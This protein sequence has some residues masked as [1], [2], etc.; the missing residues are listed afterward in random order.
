MDAVQILDRYRTSLASDREGLL[1]LARLLRLGSLTEQELVRHTRIPHH[2]L[3]LK[4][5][6]LFRAQLACMVAGGRWTTTD[7]AEETLSRL[8][9]ASVVAR[10]VLVDQELSEID[11]SFLEACLEARSH[12]DGRWPRYQ[13]T[14]LRSLEALREKRLQGKWSPEKDRGEMS[15]SIVVGLDSDVQQLGG[16]QYCGS[17]LDWHRERESDLWA[18][19]GTAWFKNKEGL[20]NKCLIAAERALKSNSIMSVDWTKGEETW[21]VDKEAAV[22][23]FIRLVGT[24][25]SRVLD[26][27]IAASFRAN[28]RLAF[29]AWPALERKLPDLEDSLYEILAQLGKVDEEARA[30][31]GRRWV[32]SRLSELLSAEESSAAGIGRLADGEVQADL[33]SVLGPVRGEWLERLLVRIKS[34]I[35]EG[36]YDHVSISQR[37]TLGR[38]LLEASRAIEDRTSLGSD[39]EAS[40]NGGEP[41]PAVGRRKRRR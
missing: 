4:M 28:H 8:G 35:D 17:I 9:I 19:Y 36:H 7:L 26:P 1:I 37:T 30:A 25:V 23:T 18:R 20:D 32:E 40:P 16:P 14:L 41:T 34:Q 21:P 33:Q 31:T 27:G 10:S 6:E 24:T 5:N 15:F 38:L 2:L 13:T 22:L 39:S 12:K 3:S 11:R 29:S